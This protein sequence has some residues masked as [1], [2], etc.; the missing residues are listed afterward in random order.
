MPYVPEKD[1]GMRIDPPWSHPTAMSTSPR[2]VST[3][4][5]EEEPPAEYPVLWGLCTGPQ[6]FVWLPPERQR[7]SQ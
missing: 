3:A 4:H 2:A 1:E 7:A 5:P 6:A